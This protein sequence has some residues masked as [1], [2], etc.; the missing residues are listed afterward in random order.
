MASASVLCC[1]G[2]NAQQRGAGDATFQERPSRYH[3]L[4]GHLFAVELRLAAGVDRIASQLFT[5]LT[6]SMV[7]WFTMSARM[8]VPHSCQ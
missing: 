3:A 6:T 2:D 8:C 7:H 1:T 5:Q 4:M